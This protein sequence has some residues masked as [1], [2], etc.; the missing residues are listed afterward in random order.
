MCTLSE[1]CFFLL[2]AKINLD[3]PTEDPG[4]GS[5]KRPQ[6][7]MT[8]I[9]HFHKEAG[10]K[11]FIQT[12][13]QSTLGM[14]QIPSKFIDSFGPIPWKIT[15]LTN[16]GCSWMVTTKYHGGRPSSIRGGQPLPLPMT[17]GWLLPHLL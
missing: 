14:L 10:L 13:F 6:G 1:V 5:S 4:E 17:S 2:Q 8:N 11:N 9:G 3:A 7:R 15:I 12:I 16:T